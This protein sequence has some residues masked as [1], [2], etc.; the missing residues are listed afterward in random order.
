MSVVYFLGKNFLNNVVFSLPREIIVLHNVTF[1]RKY[2]MKIQARNTLH[3]ELA[4]IL[5]MFELILFN[6][7]MLK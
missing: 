5:L 4:N 6:I 1:Q 2:I 7:D 3:Y